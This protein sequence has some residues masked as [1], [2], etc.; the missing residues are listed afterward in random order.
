LRHN[1]RMV[2]KEVGASNQE[3]LKI[4]EAY[5]ILSYPVKKAFLDLYGA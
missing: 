5:E 3:Y 1:N 4:T 2:T